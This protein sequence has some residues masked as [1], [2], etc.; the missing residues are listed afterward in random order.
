MPTRCLA[1]YPESFPGQWHFG[2]VVR[3]IEG[4][5]ALKSFQPI[6]QLIQPVFPFCP[7]LVALRA[8]QRGMGW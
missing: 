8:L 3:F 1:E 5:D 2:H 7:A 4:D 6:A